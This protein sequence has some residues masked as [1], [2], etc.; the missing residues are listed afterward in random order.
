MAGAGRLAETAL[1]SGIGVFCI[2]ALGTDLP[3]ALVLGLPFVCA[4]TLLLLQRIEWCLAVLAFVI[5]TNLADVLLARYGIPS[6]TKL[7]FGVVIAAVI[8]RWSLGHQ[9]LHLPVVAI[10]LVLIY[11]VLRIVSSLY[12]MDS[13]AALEDGMAYFKEAMIGL[14]FATLVVDAAAFRGVLWAALA[15]GGL[16]AAL[17]TYQV[18]T[19]NYD[20]E[21][22]GL[23]KAGLHQIV[24]ELDSYRITG[25]LTDPNFY[26]QTLVALVPVAVNR[27]AGERM[28]MLKF[29]AALVAGVLVTAIVFSYSRGA[30]L[31]LLCVA[32]AMALVWRPKPRHILAAAAVGCMMLPFVPASYYDR[33][34]AVE[35]TLDSDSRGSDGSIQGRMAQFQVGLAMVGNHPIT[36]VGAGNYP[37]NFE[38]YT[39]LLQVENRREEREAHSLY[40]EVLA[41][42]GVV[43]FVVF[44]ALLLS[45]A[46]SIYTGVRTLDG[47]GC[48]DTANLGRALGFGLMG[49][50]IAAV[51]L[52]SAWPEYFWLLAGLAWALPIVARTEA[53]MARTGQTGVQ[54]EG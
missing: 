36:G 11:G 28:P 45:L 42:L 49:Y 6:V 40:L 16:V 50:G 4:A 7:L 13:G 9:K 18:V 1:F 15:G 20:M 2:A 5:Y 31:A 21:F 26:A 3:P 27:I 35:T 54:Q 48:R 19:G 52:H 32:A 43:G 39:N 29:L 47:A 51:W 22:G 33:I 30:L 37:V 24:G 25:P 17:S 10:L 44:C 41:E 14:L 23:A 12:A 38:Q 34:A 8:L 53:G 46:V